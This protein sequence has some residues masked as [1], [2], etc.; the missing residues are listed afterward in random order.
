MSHLNQKLKIRKSFAKVKQIQDLPN[1]LKIPKESYQR[2]L[3][4]NTPP[5]RRQDIGIHRCFLS[6]FPIKDYSEIAVLEYIDYKILSP[7]YSPD[8][9]KEKGLTYEVP[10]KLKVRLVTYNL[11]PETGIKSIK[12]IKE[13]EIYFGT[14][15][16]MT[17]DGRFIINGTER[18]VVNQLQRSPGVIFEK[19]KTHAKAGRLTYIGRVIPVKGSWLDFVY[20]YKGRFLVRI[21]KRKNIP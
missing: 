5:D 14:I 12:D 8:E 13:Q 11:D 16:M 19:D 1:L 10:M 17:E 20:D 2:F 6:I 9:A 3:Q 15:P 7:E 21:D 18:A 4:A